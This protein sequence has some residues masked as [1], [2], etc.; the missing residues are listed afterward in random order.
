LITGPT[1]VYCKDTE[2]N[3]TQYY[4]IPEGDSGTFEIILE[5]P[6]SRMRQVG[7]GFTI[8]QAKIGKNLLA[9][10][11]TIKDFSTAKVVKLVIVKSYCDCNCPQCDRGYHCQS[12][13]RNCWY[14]A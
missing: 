12:S 3:I 8:L 5:A 10:N 2:G 9:K 4:L 6:T 13:H 11:Q 14:T 1:K 7:T